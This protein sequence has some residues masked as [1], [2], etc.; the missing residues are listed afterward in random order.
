MTQKLGSDFPH[1]DT[2]T[3]FSAFVSCGGGGGGGWKPA[4]DISIAVFGHVSA[5]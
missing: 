1:R 3:P 4:L 2:P 5:R